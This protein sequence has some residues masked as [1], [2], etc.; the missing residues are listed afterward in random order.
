M[1]RRGFLGSPDWCDSLESAV[2]M[3]DLRWQRLR[4]L[5]VWIGS[6]PATTAAAALQ[7]VLQDAVGTALSVEAPVVECL[8]T[9]V[10]STTAVG[11]T[12]TVTLR[13]PPACPPAMRSPST[14]SSTRVPTLDQKAQPSPEALWRGD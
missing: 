7:L 8:S 2:D 3:I 12:A 4:E 6:R 9:S 10:R 14:S 11:A 13:L 5:G 1:V